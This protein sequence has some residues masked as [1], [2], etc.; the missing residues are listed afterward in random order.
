MKWLAMTMLA[1]STLH[2]AASADVLTPIMTTN[3]IIDA[4]AWNFPDGKWGTTVN[5]QTFQQEAVV[6]HNGH[7]YASYFAD[8]GVLAIARRKLPNGPWQTIHFPDYTARDHRDAHN[9]NAIGIATGDGTI[10]LSFDH[11]CNDLHY[12]RSVQGLASRPDD[13]EWTAAQFG[14]VT[15]KLD[16]TK[17]LSNVTYPQ[18]FD[19]PDGKLQLV[20]RIGSSGNGSWYLAEYDPT[21]KGQWTTRG[22]LLSQEGRYESSPSRCAYPNPMRYDANGRLHMTWT[23]REMPAGQ[24]FDLRTN[25]DLLYAYSDDRGRT[26]RNNAGATIA[27]LGSTAIGIDTAGVVIAPTKFLW[28]QM[29]TTTQVV[30]ARGRVHVINWQQPPEAPAGSKDV[31][32]W[33][34]F[35]YW[36]DTADGAWHENRLPFHGRKPQI[37]VDRGGR[38]I[39]VYAKADD[40]NYHGSDPGGTLTIVTAPESS[41]WTDWKTLW[42]DDRASVGEPLLDHR[43]WNDE[44]VLSIYTQDKPQ[45]PGQPSALRVLDF[46]GDAQ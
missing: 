4:A 5:G 36:R 9:V 30:D 42:T 10:H 28:G 27:V 22:M 37:A 33:R 43:R 35:H 12:R 16:G 15:A 25:H 29:N 24:P 38:A 2:A 46:K 17:A 31:N 6:T 13:F 40:A 41:N 3:S 21:G 23:W 45:R 26:W 20:Y 1:L 34:Y 7:Q 39:V 8:K 19:A 11:H 32:T 14:P 44:G 18:F